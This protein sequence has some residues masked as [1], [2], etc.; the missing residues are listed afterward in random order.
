MATLNLLGGAKKLQKVA[1][2]LHNILNIMAEIK[3]RTVAS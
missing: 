2:Q 3:D 1:K